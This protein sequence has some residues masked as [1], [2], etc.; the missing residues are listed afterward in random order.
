MDVGKL[1]NLSAREGNSIPVIALDPNLFFLAWAVHYLDAFW[2]SNAL[3][4][5]LAH[6]VGEAEFVLGI[7]DGVLDWEV[8]SDKPHLIAIALCDAGDHVLDMAK[9]CATT[10][11]E[12][13]VAEPAASEDLLGLLVPLDIK[14]EM[15]EV[16][17][18]LATRTSHGNNTR[19]NLDLDAVLFDVQVRGVQN[20][21]GHGRKGQPVTAPIEDR[22]IKFLFDVG[23]F[24]CRC[25]LVYSRGRCSLRQ[26]AWSHCRF[27]L[28]CK[29]HAYVYSSDQ[30]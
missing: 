20:R 2:G 16:T 30:V 14:T 9:E 28:L 4:L 24:A 21:A 5:T 7:T 19:L 27:W 23:D 6:E 1:V 22:T 15:A 10:S 29:W 18:E 13:A 25:P 8:S 17:L 3:L 11:D 26:N 12:L